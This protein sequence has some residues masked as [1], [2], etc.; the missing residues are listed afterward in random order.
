MLTRLVA[1]FGF[2]GLVLIGTYWVNRALGIFDQLIADGQSVFVFLELVA[3]FLP[4]VMAFM[5]PVAVMAATLYV[6]NQMMSDSELVIFEAAGMSPWRSLRPVLVFGVL[7]AVLAGILA[8]FLVPESRYQTALRQSRIKAD[9]TSRM[10]TEG[11][12]VSPASGITFYIR[13]LD[14]NGE[15]LD[16]FLHDTRTPGQELTYTARRAVLVRDVSGPKL[17]MFDG[18]LQT[19]ETATGLLSV[20][21]F[22]DLSYDLAALVASDRTPVRRFRD[23]PTPALFAP[24]P[25]ML[26]TTGASLQ[27]FLEEAHDRLVQ[28]LRP[29]AYALLSGSI[30][31]LGAFSRL[32]ATMQ[33]IVAILAILGLN[34]LDL[35]VPAFVHAN[36]DTWPLIYLPDLSAILLSQ[37]I[38]L[39]A[40]RPLWPRLRRQARSQEVTA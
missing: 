26:A 36:P 22:A 33:V 24:S 19:L 1:S 31:L 27:D 38:L 20:V 8:H 7:A 32:G 23:Y 12:F 5:L 2:F 37:L 10:V 34:A 28:T 17:V 13:Q 4:Q 6:L 39:R 30:L 40:R 16:I 35:S 25:A 18:T 9:V 29:V 14:E 15:L 3:L 21:G 11:Q